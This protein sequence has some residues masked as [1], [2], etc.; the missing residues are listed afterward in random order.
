MDNELEVAC[1]IA[2]A[3][4]ASVSGGVGMVVTGL[5][6]AE[7][8]A[9][10]YPLEEG[11]FITNGGGQVRLMGGRRANK[12]IRRFD[13]ALAN[14]G[15]ESGRTSRGTPEAARQLASALNARADV[16]GPLDESARRSVA[17]A[18]QETLVLGPLRDL[19]NLQ[20]LAADYLPAAG[21]PANVASIMAAAAERKAAGAVAQHLVGAKLQLRYPDLTIE[22][23]SFTTADSATGRAGDFRIADTVFHVTVAPGPQLLEKCK[24]NIRAGLRPTVITPSHRVAGLESNLDL[25]ELRSQVTVYCL[26]TFIA[27]NL[28]ELAGFNGSQY[29]DSFKALL[30]LYNER[31]NDVEADKSLLIKL[32]ASLA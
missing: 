17:D 8:F 16:F 2:R 5:I 15:T 25:E 20:R 22:N 31:V 7:H 4:Y 32:P 9:A 21:T 24:S 1:S 6:M 13:A 19:R 30:E 27:Q 26:E 11:D 29:R 23:Y 18:I 10:N 3:W 12:I 14:L 28:E